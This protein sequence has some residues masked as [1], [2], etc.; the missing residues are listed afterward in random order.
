MKL[1]VEA[2]YSMGEIVYLKTDPDQ[3]PRIVYSYEIYPN[4]RV[5]YGLIHD[6]RTSVHYDFEISREKTVTL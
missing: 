6:T 2:E 1:C 4:Q 3:L 5:L